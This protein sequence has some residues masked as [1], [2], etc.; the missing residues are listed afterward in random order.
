MN[1]IDFINLRIGASKIKRTSNGYKPLISGKDN[2][3][4]WF[5]KPFGNTREGDISLSLF[6]YSEGEKI[7]YKI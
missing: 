1:I 6:N 7:T 5:I 4:I 2:V 3:S